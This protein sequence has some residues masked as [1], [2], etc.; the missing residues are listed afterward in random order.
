MNRLL[1]V[2]VIIAA[3]VSTSALA[4]T[5]DIKQGVQSK[6]PAI[7]QP[8]VKIKNLPKSSIL[9]QTTPQGTA[10]L[11]FQN[12]EVM[13]AFQSQPSCVLKWVVTLTNTGT[14]PSSSSL[15]L[16]HKYRKS[17]ADTGVEGQ[18]INLDSIS[19]GETRG[20]TGY[21][22]ER[23]DGRTEVILEIRDGGTLLETTVYVLPDTIKPSSSNIALGDAVI[24][25]SQ[26]SITVRN[27]GNVDVNP[28]SIRVRGLDAS[29]ASQQLALGPIMPCVPAGGSETVAV[30]IPANSYQAYKVQ[31]SP[32]GL[33][34]IIAERDYPKP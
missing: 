28:I 22:P 32:N 21:V 17:E 33:S 19:P 20:T 3:L 10:E 13:P 23:F 6:N 34:E 24:S 15:K 18:V 25:G 14:K 26:I 30:Q 16:H 5:T 27:T 9:P 1:G 29:G 12:F 2:A 4:G 11:H 8:Q 31:L 7:M